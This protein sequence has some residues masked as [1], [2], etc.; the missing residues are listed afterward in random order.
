MTKMYITKTAED[1]Y[2]LEIKDPFSHEEVNG[3]QFLGMASGRTSPMPALEILRRLDSQHIGYT[4]T[5]DY[6]C[7]EDYMGPD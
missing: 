4:M 3:M 6:D 7:P 5:I 2:Q 1:H